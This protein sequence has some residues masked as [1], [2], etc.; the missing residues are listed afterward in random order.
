[1]T[2]NNPTHSDSVT[3]NALGS[4]HLKTLLVPTD[5]SQ[6]STR[7]VQYAKTLSQIFH[8]K[9]ILL[10]V[11]IPVAAPD[12]VYGPM[13][14]DEGKAI[15]ASKKRLEKCVEEAKFEKSIPV[16]T[17]V[18][19]GHPTQVITELSKSLKV[20]M[21]IISTHGH[22]GLKHLLLGSVVERVIRHAPCPVLVVREKEHEFI[23]VPEEE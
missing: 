4:V 18:K 15:Q 8:S 16:Q 13:A 5:F 7:A 22:T 6:N 2:T 3:E 9:V 11:I 19:M 12:L 10:H 14:W 20:D 1:M 23:T 17:L 21:L